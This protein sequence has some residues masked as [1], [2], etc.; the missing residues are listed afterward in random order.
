M[1]TE[2]LI[3]L[4]LI[5][6]HWVLIIM[7]LHSLSSVPALGPTTGKKEQ[8]LAHIAHHISHHYHKARITLNGHGIWT[9]TFSNL[10]HSVLVLWG[11]KYVKTIVRRFMITAGNNVHYR[12]NFKTHDQD[13][14]IVLIL[15]DGKESFKGTLQKKKWIF[16]QVYQLLISFQMST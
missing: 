15:S 2:L 9:H 12:W 5:I 8:L 3:K 14:S 4:P 10:L 7:T 16:V 11:C 6:R 13:L 1:S